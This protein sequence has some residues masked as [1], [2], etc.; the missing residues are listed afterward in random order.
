MF[1]ICVLLD[2]L[3]L[4]LMKF[5]WHS[6]WRRCTAVVVYGQQGVLKAKKLT[7]LLQENVRIPVEILCRIERVR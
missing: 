2:M 1:S 5:F 6:V 3:R 7:F 4:K